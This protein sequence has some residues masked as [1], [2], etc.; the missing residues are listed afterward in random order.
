MALFRLKVRRLALPLLLAA[1][2]LRMH[3]DLDWSRMAAGTS[4]P[5]AMLQTVVWA[6]EEPEDLR[7]APS[8]SVGVAYLDQ[9]LLLSKP[10]GASS[11]APNLFVRS[12]ASR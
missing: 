7:T 6:W 12:R 8:G 3:G 1:S 5:S 11:D 10:Q 2:C 9:T 4:F